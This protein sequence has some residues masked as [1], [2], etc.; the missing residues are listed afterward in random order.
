M[1]VRGGNRALGFFSGVSTSMLALASWSVPAKA[2]ESVDQKE[3][4]QKE[5]VVTAERRDVSLQKTNL[6]VSALTSKDLERKSVASI[7]D[8]QSATPSLSVIDTG[9]SK[10]LNIRGIG[11]S[12]VNPAVVPGVAT[13]RDGVFNATQDT[14]GEPFFDIASV[15]V[16]RGPQGTFVGQNA[17]G[18]AVFV[19][20]RNPS[21]SDGVSGEITGQYGNYN[22][23]LLR[24][25]V[26]LPIDDT[27]AARVAF[28]VE[29]R[30]SFFD[31]LTSQVA[32]PGKLDT[33]NL[34]VGLLWQPVENLQIVFKT[35]Y[36][37]DATD[38]YAYK[39][40]AGTQY[41]PLA[42]A[43][44]FSLNYD[45][46][47]TRFSTLYVR[48]SLQIDYK[49][50]SGL[51]L[52]SVTGLQYNRLDLLN[53]SDATTADQYY[54]NHAIERTTT[55]DFSIISPDSGRFR[56]VLGG[57]FIHYS[58]DVAVAQFSPG[59]TTDIALRSKKA[60]W[61]A[62]ANFTYSLTDTLDVDIGGRYSGDKGKNAGDIRLNF[63]GLPTPFILPLA[64]EGPTGS[65]ATG[66]AALNWKVTPDHLL[67]AFWARGYKP[68]G[69]DLSQATFGS[70]K[71]DDFEAGW[72]GALFDRRLRVQADAFYMRYTGFQVSTF[73][74]ITTQTAIRNAGNSTIKGF[75]VTGQ[76]SLR[77]LRADF[78]VSHVDSKIGA[79]TLVNTN[80]LPNGSASGLPPQCR[81]GGPAPCFD[82]GPATVSVAGR[83][84][85][86]SPG[87]TFNA[88][89]EHTIA[90]A[91]GKMTPRVDVSYLSSQ[92]ST[93]FENPLLDHFA[94]RTLMNLQL[95][96]SK[97]D[98]TIQGYGT[99]IL[100][101]TY[102]SGAEGN[103]RFYGARRQYGLRV[104][105]SF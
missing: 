52:R 55:Q 73:D 103:N 82:Y 105:R 76:L 1:R 78:G 20:S 19:N 7:S 29:H 40:A 70:E 4:D 65:A 98:W 88:G 37:T 77:G 33:A 26:N 45:R 14:Y 54:T 104:S 56:W 62:F 10:S 38:G 44:P 85:I 81:P 94:P 79:T 99:N 3:G 51:H 28:N 71:V 49:F 31:N 13:Y 60:A 80:L 9:F 102:I 41:A 24:G 50:D 32:H 11:L 59:S 35:Q 83:S 58:D 53:D 90:F 23:V 66:K 97:G 17:T 12:V 87:W 22:D 67:F 48:S 69:V 43:D 21:L 96:Y 86:Y 92:W 47:D 57:T 46:T 42:P 8:L 25:A 18:G 36:N 100:N 16:L 64:A 15:E 75:E 63:A 34:R 93:L 74:P 72:K 95:T 27:L 2:Q 84:N 39:P 6:A 30:K 68:G 5:I 89:L 61:G 101:K 91:G